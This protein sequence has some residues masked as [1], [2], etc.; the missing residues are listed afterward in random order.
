ML[1]PGFASL[2]KASKLKNISQYFYDKM[3]ILEMKADYELWCNRIANVNTNVEVL[4]VLEYSKATYYNM[5]KYLLIVLATNPV[6]RA[7]AERS[8]STMQKIQILS[9]CIMAS[10]R[11]SRLAMICTYLGMMI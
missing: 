3:L 5:N 10:E 7:R 6:S 1:L 2:Q 11:L 8:F 4:I 9:Q